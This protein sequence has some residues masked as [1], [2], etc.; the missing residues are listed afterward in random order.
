[1][2]IL[3]IM[4]ITVVS[5]FV[6]KQISLTTDLFGVKSWLSRKELVG[7]S[8]ICNVL[9]ILICV[10]RPGFHC[11]RTYRMLHFHTLA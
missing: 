5:Y 1:M 10:P 6:T 2:H 9:F 11:A 7:V 8:L 3:N 4:K